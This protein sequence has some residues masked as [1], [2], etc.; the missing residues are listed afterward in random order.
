MAIPAP[1]TRPDILHDL[2]KF[3]ITDKNQFNDWI[4]AVDL[5]AA[6][7]DGIIEVVKRSLVCPLSNKFFEDPII[8]VECGH[9]F[10][11]GSIETFWNETKKCYTCLRVSQKYVE[12]RVIS[13][14]AQEIL[15]VLTPIRDSLER[16]K[17]LKTIYYVGML[18]RIAK[19]YE[20][21]FLT[22]PCGHTENVDPEFLPALLSRG[23]DKRNVDSERLICQVSRCSAHVEQAVVHAGLKSISE[24]I[25]QKLYPLVR[26]GLSPK[27]K[28][29][30]RDENY[31]FPENLYKTPLRKIEDIEKQPFNGEE[32]NI[33]KA[34]CDLESKLNA[35][36]LF[37][38]NVN[39]TL[40]R[41]YATLQNSECSKE[42]HAAFS[43]LLRNYLD[44]C[45]IY[46]EVYVTTAN[47]DRFAKFQAY[48]TWISVLLDSK[49]L[50]HTIEGKERF[51]NLSNFLSNIANQSAVAIIGWNDHQL[52]CLF[53]PDLLGFM[54]DCFKKIEN[55]GLKIK[56]QIVLDYFNYF[57]TGITKTIERKE[58]R[59]RAVIRQTPNPQLPD[60][61]L[62]WLPV[63]LH[64]S[65]CV[66]FTDGKVAKERY[67]MMRFILSGID[68]FYLPIFKSRFDEEGFKALYRDLKAKLLKELPLMEAWDGRRLLDMFVEFLIIENN[69]FP[70][71]TVKQYDSVKKAA[72]MDLIST[73]KSSPNPSMKEFGEHVADNM[74][75]RL[76]DRKITD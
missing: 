20:S 76:I 24:A 71:Y 5:D 22:S 64:G 57:F 47:E 6:V 18:T 50:E 51:C 30:V 60:I 15:K 39:T 48:V 73:L 65:N 74:H 10:S 70:S 67:E 52:W 1:E 66:E 33:L 42:I 2:R 25:N 72:L 49:V 44:L 14:T 45:E 63:G 28:I 55:K 32:Q 43:S 27:S 68:S 46:G 59:G 36:T 29:N 35:E 26:R 61:R 40:L 54:I 31:R 19:L 37:S 56:Q 23:S 3:K 13:V 34:L 69:L 12:D 21:P 11:K 58:N 38:L 8:F 75:V 16:F 4:Y 53:N 9:E 17:K 62:L 7:L 41:V